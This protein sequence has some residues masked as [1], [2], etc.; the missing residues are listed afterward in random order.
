MQLLVYSSALHT[1]THLGF[2]PILHMPCVQLLS[3]VLNTKVFQI[4][5]ASV[6]LIDSAIKP[7]TFACV[8]L[9]Y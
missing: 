9:P 2:A 3:V 6:Y 4:G 7:R 8:T 1:F 5:A